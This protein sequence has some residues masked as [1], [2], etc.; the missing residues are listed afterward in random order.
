MARSGFPDSLLYC[1][2]LRAGA[3]P[4]GTAVPATVFSGHRL[5][6]IDRKTQ[7]FPTTPLVS[8]A[9]RS[10]VIGASREVLSCW[11]WSVLTLSAFVRI[12]VPVSISVAVPVPVSFMPC[13]TLFYR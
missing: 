12:P 1:A 11:A 7:E 8:D 10:S 2:V 9:T 3:Q 5:Q 13:R 6:T 4:H